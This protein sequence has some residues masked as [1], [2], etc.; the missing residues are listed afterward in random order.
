VTV[1]EVCL[2]ATVTAIPGVGEEVGAGLRGG[3]E[4][5]AERFRCDHPL[6]YR[7]LLSLL[8]EIV[9]EEFLRLEGGASSVEG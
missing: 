4:T 2:V 7:S 6:L 8:E 9:L 1:A 3:G 5:V